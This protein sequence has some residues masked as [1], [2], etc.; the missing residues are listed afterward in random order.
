MIKSRYFW[1]A[2]IMLALIPLL[3]IDI[4]QHYLDWQK[5]VREELITVVQ[6]LYQFSRQQKADILDRVFERNQALGFLLFAKSFAI[7]VLL[8][9]SFYFFGKFKQ[10]QP[11][12]GRPLLLTTA[13]VAVVVLAKIYLVNRLNNN[14]DI[15]FA[16]IAAS[17][18][19]FSNVYRDNFKGQLV[20]ID[21][22]GTTCGPCLQEFRDFTKPLKD[23][24]RLRKDI[25]FLYVAQGNEY[26]W[27]EQ[28]KKYNV[29]GTHL[30]L[31]P[32]QY[33]KLY[34]Q[35]THDSLVLMPHYLLLD[36]NGHIA[37]TK[38]RQPSDRDS[39]YAQIDQYLAGN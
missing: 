9:L 23:R 31:S 3:A 39:L 7:V 14:A 22:W 35:S 25:A 5:E 36:K 17:D 37:E 29:T 13:L 11:G 8:P 10:Q 30:F 18:S 15:R 12:F 28:I 24:Y 19:T 4:V 21:F 32:E 27:H 34:K 2:A 1:I 6:G 20:Y 38:A 26:L 16:A 33:E